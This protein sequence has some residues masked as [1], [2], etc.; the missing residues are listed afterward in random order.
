MRERRIESAYDMKES[1]ATNVYLLQRILE[2]NTEGSNSESS[3][4]GLDQMVRV[5][6]WNSR[7]I[8]DELKWLRLMLSFGGSDKKEYMDL[9][10]EKWGITLNAEFIHISFHRP[11]PK[12][13]EDVS[14]EEFLRGSI[15]PNHRSIGEVMRFWTRV[16][17]LVLEK[18]GGP[19]GYTSSR[20]PAGRIRST[21]VSLVT[22]Q[23][24]GKISLP[25]WTSERCLENV[26]SVQAM[27]TNL[28]A[29]ISCRLGLRG[30]QVGLDGDAWTVSLY[31][32][33]RRLSDMLYE[34]RGIQIQIERLKGQ[35]WKDGD[36]KDLGE[37]MSLRDNHYGQWITMRWDEFVVQGEVQM[38]LWEAG[39]SRWDVG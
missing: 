7:M 5:C 37:W 36:W 10:I 17:K 1:T 9:F 8:E 14:V 26:R 34:I 31:Q 16:E 13:F 2:S 18:A 6:E 38:P 12:P 23:R 19:I 27:L 4:Q 28:Y 3:F 20:G 35:R 22:V 33:L 15:T 24:D 21:V 25:K 39:G 11:C 29:D 32:A 30:A